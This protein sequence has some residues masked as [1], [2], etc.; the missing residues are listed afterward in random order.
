MFGY[1]QCVID[2]DSKVAHSTF[3]LCVS[4]QELDRSQIL[5]VTVDKG[6][7]RAPQGVG[8]VVVWVLANERNPF[9]HDPRIL[10]SGEVARPLVAARKQEV[11][12]RVI[13]LCNPR[14]NSR[15]RLLRDLEADGLA[16]LLLQDRGAG[17]EMRAV[18]DIADPQPNQVAAAQLAVDGEVEEGKIANPPANLQPDAD[19]PDVLERAISGRSACPYSMGPRPWRPKSRML[20]GACSVTS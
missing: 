4:E 10:A 19:A 6:C 5:R 14:L 18:G 8:P 12:R 13:P 20:P 15:P 9:L 17:D 16:G 7:L 11:S 2:F 3:E 1:L